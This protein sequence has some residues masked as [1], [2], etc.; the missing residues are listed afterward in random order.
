MNLAKL[1]TDS[2]DLSQVV[3]TLTNKRNGATVSRTCFRHEIPTHVRQ[4]VKEQCLPPS[5][6]SLSILEQ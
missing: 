1:L 5:E 2:P 4:F 3:L 6:V